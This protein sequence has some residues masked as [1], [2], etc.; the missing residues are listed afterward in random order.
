MKRVAMSRQLFIAALNQMEQC[1][2][3]LLTSTLGVVYIN[4]N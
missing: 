3:I 4:L 1:E 2:S